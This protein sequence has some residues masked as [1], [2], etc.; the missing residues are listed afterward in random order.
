MIDA[1]EALDAR[2]FRAFARAFAG[3]MLCSVVPELI[4]TSGIFFAVTLPIAP[5]STL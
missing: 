1:K 2:G 4:V 3:G 5:W